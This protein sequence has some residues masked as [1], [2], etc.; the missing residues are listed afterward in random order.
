M[1]L[2]KNYY[3]DLPK[4]TVS[5]TTFFNLFFLQKKFFSVVVVYILVF[6]SCFISCFRVSANNAGMGF[7][8]IK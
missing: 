7:A 2:E 4:N 5:T 6:I 8:D 3:I 1:I